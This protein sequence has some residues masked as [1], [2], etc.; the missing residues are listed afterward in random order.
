M[1]EL[2]SPANLSQLLAS[3]INDSKDTDSERVGIATAVANEP[4]ESGDYYE[5]ELHSQN[6]RIT[7]SSN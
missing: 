7:I 1:N 5:I 4:N 6:Y 3:W 2:E